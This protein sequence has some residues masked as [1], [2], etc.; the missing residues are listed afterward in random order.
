MVRYAA[1][2][3]KGIDKMV[4]IL[5]DEMTMDMR[6]LGTHT[7]KDVQRWQGLLEQTFILDCCR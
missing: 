5:A 4:D 2:G 1:Y 6:L 3:P 7:I